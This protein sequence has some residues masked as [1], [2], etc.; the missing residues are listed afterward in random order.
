MHVIVPLRD[1]YLRKDGRFSDRWSGPR[2][3]GRRQRPRGTLG[4]RWVGE[5]GTGAVSELKE[6]PGLGE[7]GRGK[8]CRGLWSI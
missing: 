8:V 6:A 3:S 7:A 1:V 2:W 5:Q 4:V